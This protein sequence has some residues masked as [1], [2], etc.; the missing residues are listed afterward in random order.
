M[1]LT[2]E[3]R[4]YNIVNEER[5]NRAYKSEDGKKF[6]EGYA[7]VFNQRSKLLYEYIDGKFQEF[8]EVI[9]LGSFDNVLRS[10][11]IDVRLT[12]NHS[13][14]TILGRYTKEN[15]EF[16]VHT[17]ELS[18]DDYGLKYRTEVPNTTLGSDIYE[19][20]LR[21]DLFENSFQF[22]ITS[23]DEKTYKDSEGNLI[24][25]INNISGLY[26]TAVVVSGAYKNTLLKV[27][28]RGIVELIKEKEH[29]EEKSNISYYKKRLE[30]LKK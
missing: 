15:G 17:L 26:D 11:S 10:Q 7:S 4:L 24:R 13:F 1:E 16:I 28:S 22:G 20:I 25:E 2:R 23:N 21:G 14:D 9:L 8:Y 27:D 30:V 12:F 29:K 18:V 3:T 5:K 6:I 19:S